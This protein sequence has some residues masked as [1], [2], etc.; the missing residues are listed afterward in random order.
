MIEPSAQTYIL[1][2]EILQL[3][4]LPIQPTYTNADSAR[5]FGVSIRT[6]QTHVADGSL[7]SRKLMGRA[8]FL[9]SDLEAFLVKS[10][11]LARR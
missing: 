2:E 8:R 7:P 3:R 1:L 5:I 11:S 9:S 4:R 10:R 6:I